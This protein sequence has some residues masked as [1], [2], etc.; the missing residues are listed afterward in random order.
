MSYLNESDTLDVEEVKAAG[1]EV[2]R[3]DVYDVPDDEVVVVVIDDRRAVPAWNASDRHF[4]LEAFHPGDA[5][6]RFYAVPE[7][8]FE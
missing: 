8:R 5:G 3:S 4:W 2:D 1:R 6:V 7:E